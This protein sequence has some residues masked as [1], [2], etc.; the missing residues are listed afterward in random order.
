MML[1]PMHFL[2][3]YGSGHF[4]VRSAETWILIQ[5]SIC[6]YLRWVN[7]FLFGAQNSHIL[8]DEAWISKASVSTFYYFV[9]LHYYALWRWTTVQYGKNSTQFRATHPQFSSAVVLLP[10]IW[11]DTSCPISDPQFPRSK[12][13]MELSKLADLS[14]NV[15]A[16]SSFHP[17]DL[18]EGST[19]Y[20]ICSHTKGERNLWKQ[21][22][23]GHSVMISL[24]SCGEQD[25]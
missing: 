6:C 7:S 15:L 23:K 12:I 14:F 4:K 24:N 13:K 21:T 1:Q 22:S 2:Q 5:P 16:S 10:A 20:P 18:Q 3:K 17:V 25:Q 11:L 9:I 8:S 19:Q